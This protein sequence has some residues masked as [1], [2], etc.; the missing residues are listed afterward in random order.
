MVL[1]GLISSTL[2][3]IYTAAVYQYATTGET[4]EFFQ[5]DLV[6]NAF[7]LR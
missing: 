5:A 2:N 1:L 3:G 4:G 6:Q 7:R